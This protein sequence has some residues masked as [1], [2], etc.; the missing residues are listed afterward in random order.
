[1]AR[2]CRQR[3]LRMYET[4]CGLT[5]TATGS[6]RELWDIYRLPVVTIP[7]RV[8]CRCV[9]EPTRFFAEPECKWA[10]IASSIGHVRRGGRPVLVGTRTIEDSETLARLLGESHIPYR[11]LNGK[12]DADEAAIIAQAGQRGA[13]TLATN[14]AGRGTDIKLA[15]G[16]A[17][18]GGLHVIGSEPHE[19]TRVDRQLAGRAARQGDPGSFQLF[20]S[21]G[22]RLI[23]VHAPRLGRRMRHLADSRGEIGRD[24]SS[25]LAALQRR[26]QRQSII[27]RRNLLRHDQWLEE[28][29]GQLA[30]TE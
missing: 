5:G 26:V 21:A 28:I 23:A 18:L 20:A 3:F 19:S 11:L 22:D 15:D 29:V 17:T 24:L 7:S 27:A 6:E 9:T 16:V 13:V 8:P 10:A 2:I 1:M 30:Q 12:Q 14:M 25:E 4:V